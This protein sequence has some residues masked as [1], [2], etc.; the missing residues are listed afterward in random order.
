MSQPL[1]VRAT[2][3]SAVI[4]WEFLNVMML[5]HEAILGASEAGKWHT[6]WL[7]TLYPG[8]QTL[9]ATGIAVALIEGFLW[10][11]VFAWLFVTIYNKLLR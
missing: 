6:F 5:A 2:G 7:Q 9:N 3:W 10:P 4:C 8:F 11:W 1:S